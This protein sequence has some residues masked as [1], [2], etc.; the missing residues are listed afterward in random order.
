MSAKRLRSGLSMLYFQRLLDINNTL[1]NREALTEW[2]GTWLANNILAPILEG[3]DVTQMFFEAA[4]G[5]PQ[6]THRRDMIAIDYVL[7][8]QRKEKPAAKIVARR[9]GIKTFSEVPKLARPIRKAVDELIAT[10]GADWLE[11]KLERERPK[12][13]TTR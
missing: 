5:R 6:D 7:H 12:W 11:K 9:W 2:D 1:A 10:V 4:P 3:K 8:L 13:K